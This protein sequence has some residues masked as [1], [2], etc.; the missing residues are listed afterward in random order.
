MIR[1]FDSGCFIICRIL[2]AADNDSP[3]YNPVVDAW[4][5]EFWDFALCTLAQVEQIFRLT[6]CPHHQA[7]DFISQ[8]MKMPSYKS[9]LKPGCFFGTKCVMAKSSQI[10]HNYN[11][12]C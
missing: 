1:R 3:L 11:V 2:G 4:R 9:M 10:F 5:A 7:D 6:C 8:E 12:K